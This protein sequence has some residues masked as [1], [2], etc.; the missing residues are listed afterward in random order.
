MVETVGWDTLNGC[1]YA[2]VSEVDLAGISSRSIARFNA[3]RTLTSRKGS[4]GSY[5]GAT[6]VGLS[7]LKP[8]FYLLGLIKILASD[9]STKLKTGQAG[10]SHLKGLFRQLEGAA[11]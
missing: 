10:C 9:Y 11:F 7:C 8:R 4:S 1:N 2:T 5:V 6:R 3:F